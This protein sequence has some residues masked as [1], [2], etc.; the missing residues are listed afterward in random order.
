VRLPDGACNA[1]RLPDGALADVTWSGDGM[2][3]P[4]PPPP[5]P[6]CNEVV[7]TYRD[8][9]ARTVWLTGTFTSWAR[10]PGAGARELTRGADGVW[11]ITTRIAMTGPQQ[12]KFIVN[13]TDWVRDPTNMM[14]AD[15]GVGGVNSVINVCGG[16]AVT[17]GNATA[18]DWR[19]TVMYFALIDRFADSGADG[20]AVRDGSA[21]GSRDGEQGAGQRAS[22]GE[23]DT[24]GGTSGDALLSGPRPPHK[25]ADCQRSRRE[26]PKLTQRGSS[27]TSIFS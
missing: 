19:D 25:P 20:S 8:A 23:T 16:A 2:V 9:N 7:F 26:Y 18:F 15:D 13:G 5:P 4:P 14:T 11:S 21:D 1:A 22:E 27:S 3:E 17:C 6:P 10:N 12:Y 24:H